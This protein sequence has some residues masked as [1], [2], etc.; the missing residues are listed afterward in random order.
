[1]YGKI[2]TF[3][4]KTQGIVS[5]HQLLD[6]EKGREDTL[7][8]FSSLLHLSNQERVHCTQDELF[9]DIKIQKLN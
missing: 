9:G 3:I 5:F 2:N 1:L 8:K 7:R 4:E 6:K